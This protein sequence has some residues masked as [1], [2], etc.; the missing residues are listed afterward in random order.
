MP[1]SWIVDFVGLVDVREA[2]G[3]RDAASFNIV[4]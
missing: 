4:Q 1:L 3:H 2:Q